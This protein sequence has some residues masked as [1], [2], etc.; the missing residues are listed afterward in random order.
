MSNSKTQQTS[1]SK[2]NNNNNNNEPND[3]ADELFSRSEILMQK[4]KRAAWINSI[5]KEA[6]ERR[7]EKFLSSQQQ[8]NKAL[9]IVLLAWLLLIIGIFAYIYSSM[10]YRPAKRGYKYEL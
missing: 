2:A 3:P 9:R 4:A 6:E 7:R 1:T 8:S 10:T 5:D